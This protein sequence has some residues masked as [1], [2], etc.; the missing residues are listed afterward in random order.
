[1][2]SASKLIPEPGNLFLAISSVSTTFSLEIGFLFINKSSLF[3]WPISNS[4][5]CIIIFFPSINSKKLSAI[6]INFFL[7]DKK[8]SV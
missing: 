1:M 3:K 8:L 6:S 7:S 5:L 4:A 2:Q